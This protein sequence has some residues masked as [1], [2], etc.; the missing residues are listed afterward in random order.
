MLEKLLKQLGF[1][2]RK[3][4]E[5]EM[6]RAAEINRCNFEARQA[7]ISRESVRFKVGR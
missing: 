4:T 7:E 2:K 6:R 3:P 5:E 1:S